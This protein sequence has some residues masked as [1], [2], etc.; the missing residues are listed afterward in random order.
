ML[1]D[2]LVEALVAPAQQ[3]E[4]RLGAPARRRARRRAAGPPGV[5]AITRR[6][7]RSVD[8]VDAVE[9]AQ[10]RVHDVDAQHHARAAAERRVVDLAAAQRRVVARVDGV[11]ARGPRASALRDVALRRGT[12][13]TTRGNSVKTSSCISVLTE[14]AQVDVDPARRRR[15][16]SGRV[17]HQRHEQLA[18]RRRGRPRAPRTTGSAHHAAHDADRDVAVDARAQPS[19]SSA[20]RTRPRSSGGASRAATCS[21][22]AAQRLDASSRDVDALQAQDRPLGRC[23]RGGRSRA[24]APSTHDRAAAGSSARAAR[25]H[26][27]GAVEP[28][29]AGRRGRRR[30]SRTS[31]QSTM[32]TRTRRLSLTAAA[33][34]TVRRAWRCARRVR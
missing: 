22:R 34:T 16:P 20:P 10:R 11:A 18:R 6:C 24:R 13:R 28:V 26:V 17:A 32:S 14:E 29:R 21:V 33:L 30:A 12:T 9:R 4:R 5:S 27:E 1:D 15:R 3:R 7:A 19:R 31:T 2:A 23:R 25:G 8:R